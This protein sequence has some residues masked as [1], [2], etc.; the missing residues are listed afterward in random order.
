MS[1]TERTAHRREPAAANLDQP[2]L[3][4]VAIFVTGPGTVQRAGGT[5]RQEKTPPPQIAWTAEQEAEYKAILT[6]VRD[7]FSQPVR[8]RFLARDGRAGVLPLTAA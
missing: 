5:P 8:N 2:Q 6:Q 4:V 1:A 3:S 7:R